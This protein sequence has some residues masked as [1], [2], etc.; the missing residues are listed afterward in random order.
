[1]LKYYV[2]QVWKINICLEDNKINK[3]YFLK[4]K[5]LFQSGKLSVE[6]KNII[7]KVHTLLKKKKM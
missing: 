5:N 7:G 6:E 4:L 1:M 3:I 2:Y